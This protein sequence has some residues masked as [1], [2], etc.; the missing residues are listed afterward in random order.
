MYKFKNIF[1]NDYYSVAGPLEK[2]SK[3]K[4]CNYFIEDYY[5]GEKTPEKA[6]SKM[7]KMVINNLIKDQKPDLIIGSDLNNQ[8]IATSLAVENTN[9]PFM[10]HYCACASLSSMI[11]ILANFIISQNIQ[12][13]LILISSHTL[14]AE[15]QFR[16]PVEYGAPKPLSISQ[17]ATAAVGI[18]ISNEESKIK[19][20]SGLIGKVIDSGIKDANN[21]GAVMVPS[22]VDTLITFLKESKTDINDYDLI[23]T[24][25]LGKVGSDIFKAVLLKEHNIKIKNHLDGGATLYKNFEYSGASGPSVLPL[26]LVTK[27]LS[28]KKYQKILCLATGSLHSTLL[29]N[30]KNTIPTVTHAIY[31]EVGL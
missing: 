23:L 22:S 12:N 10:G 7:Q 15:K 14:V 25:D 4:N 16:F 2:E 31:L 28:N 30:Q 8:L 20:I 29:I 19:I 11:I 18:K 27:I 13:G 26:T 9:I 6:E 3:L 24:G 1:L 5:F 21:L 17:T